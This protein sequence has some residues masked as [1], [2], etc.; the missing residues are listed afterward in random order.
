MVAR[1]M[2]G[3]KETQQLYEGKISRNWSFYGIHGEEETHGQR[4][5]TKHPFETDK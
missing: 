5:E 2:K 1:E 3:R 4:L